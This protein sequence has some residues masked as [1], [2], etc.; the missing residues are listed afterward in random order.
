M[1][2]ALDDL[3][4]L[5]P[6]GGKR[7]SKREF[8]L[9]V[10]LRHEGHLSADDLYNLTHRDDQHISRATV[11]R[12]LQWM[13]EAGIARKVDFG[14]GRS[15]YEHSYRHPRHFHLICQSC[16]RSSEFLSS[17][18]EA[19]LEEIAAARNFSSRQSVLQIYGTCEEC[20]TGRAES[21]DAVTTELLF[22][23]D[24]LR[25]AIA[26]ERSGFEFYLRAAR[27]TRD[28]RGQGVFQRLADE[29]RDHLSTLEQRYQR[30]LAQDPRLESRPT[31]LF[32]KGA[33]N[34]LFAAGAEQVARGVDDTQALMI[35]I[36]CERASHRFFKRYGERFEDSEGKQIFLEFASEERKHLELLIREYRALARRQGRRPRPASPRRA[37]AQA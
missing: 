6:A 14:E 12:T 31:F 33:A 18:I 7:S 23:R 26:T 32:F 3:D 2:H 30:L 13:V 29:E 35:G 8:I 20:R 10:F 17:D 9:N 4:N 16:N 21:A 34:G 24:A 19:L 15:R 11:Y 25:I 37:R 28:A 22:A 27:A 1:V 5:R 36:R